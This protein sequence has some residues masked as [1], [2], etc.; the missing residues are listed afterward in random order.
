[1]IGLL[2][3]N[4]VTLTAPCRC[5]VYSQGKLIKPCFIP[6]RAVRVQLVSQHLPSPTTTAR[7]TMSLRLT[8]TGCNGRI[9][10]R[11]CAAALQAGHVVHGV[12]SIRLPD[13]LEYAANPNF[14]FREADLR[15]YDQAIEAIRG[16]EAIIQ[17]AAI[18]TPTDYLTDTHNT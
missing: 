1:M 10:R 3:H 14:T 16:S 2:K 9:G 7:I 12:D 11:V 5:R 4:A 8:V 18:P 13:N 17:L 6:P 15:N